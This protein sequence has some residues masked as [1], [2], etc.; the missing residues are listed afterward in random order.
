[1]KQE[2]IRR[3]QQKF[4]HSFLV[5]YMRTERERE[6]RANNYNSH[7]EINPT[8]HTI[9]VKTWGLLLSSTLMFF[10]VLRMNVPL[11]LLANPL[12]HNR[13]AKIAERYKFSGLWKYRTET[14]EKLNRKQRN[15]QQ[16]RLGNIIKPSSPEIFETLISKQGPFVFLSSRF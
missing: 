14:T 16:S 5:K 15:K 4:I 3:C 12:D 7:D 9:L 10:L 6:T 1:M 13:M 2:I 8:A 11:E